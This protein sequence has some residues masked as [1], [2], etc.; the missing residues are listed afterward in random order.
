MI[1]TI[2]DRTEE[3]RGESIYRIQA[4]RLFGIQMATKNKA[5]T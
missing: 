5:H 2:R 4:L 1:E 3:E